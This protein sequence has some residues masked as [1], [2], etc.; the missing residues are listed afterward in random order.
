MPRIPHQTTDELLYILMTKKR[1]NNKPG[2]GKTLIILTGHLQVA[3]QKCV[4]IGRNRRLR[5]V[6]TWTD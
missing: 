6:Q 4:K 3:L 1:G 2:Q 5:S